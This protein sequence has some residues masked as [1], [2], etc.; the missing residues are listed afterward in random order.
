[1]SNEEL[2]LHE[3]P[4]APID[5]LAEAAAEISD[6]ELNSMLFTDSSLDALFEVLESDRPEKSNKV[7]IPEMLD[8]DADYTGAIYG[9]I[10]EDSGYHVLLGWE[11]HMTALEMDAQCVGAICTDDASEQEWIARLSAQGLTSALIGRRTDGCVSYRQV[12]FCDSTQDVPLTSDVYTLRQNIFSRNSGLLETSWM[13]G[14]C[15]VISGC[16]SVGSC[17]ALQLARSGV[18]RFVLVDTDCMEIHNVCR[19]Q[20]SLKDV[21]R[22]KVDAVAERIRQINPDA[23]IKVFYQ[24]IQEVPLQKYEEWVKDGNAL[25]IGTCDN[26]VGNAYACDAA[27]AVGAPFVALGYMDRA[28]AGE[29]FVYLPQRGDICYRCAYSKQIAESIEEERRNHHYLDAENAETAHVVPGLDVDIEYGVCLLNKIALDVMNIGNRKYYH[30]LL[31]NIGQLTY[32]SG[33]A[34]RS[35]AGEFWKR[36]LPQPLSLQR[37][38]FAEDMRRCDSCLLYRRRR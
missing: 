22:Y 38:G 1:M 34:D 15:V 10:R 21:G 37:A 36:A 18:S 14:K 23:E 7:M 6:E 26:R 27:V 4:P 17:V 30:R 3:D 13:D 20:C 33:T 8:A 19:H 11:G 5:P 35:T 16:G 2:N 28:W 32:F 31:L 9:Y 29:I 25:F 24:R 12:C